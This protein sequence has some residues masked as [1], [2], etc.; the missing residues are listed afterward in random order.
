MH[1]CSSEHSRDRSTFSLTSIEDMAGNCFSFSIVTYVLLGFIGNF[2]LFLFILV[3]LAL[4]M[5]DFLE[6][7]KVGQILPLS[8]IILFEAKHVLKNA[9]F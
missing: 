3:Q 7:A 5:G 1:R 9:N 2:W 6:N 8:Q 4:K